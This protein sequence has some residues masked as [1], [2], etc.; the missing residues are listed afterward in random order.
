[1]TVE[2]AISDLKGVCPLLSFRVGDK[3]VQTLATTTFA[4]GNCS[5]LKDRKEVEVTGAVQ[6][7]GLILATRVELK[8]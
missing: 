2:G 7:G 3:S 5:K 8:N 1:L 6:L 4:G